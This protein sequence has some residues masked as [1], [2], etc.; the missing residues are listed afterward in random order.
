MR[1]KNMQMHL[2]EFWEAPDN[3][4]I[5]IVIMLDDGVIIIII[6]ICSI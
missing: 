4:L 2:Y 5:F 3:K 1:R 6:I